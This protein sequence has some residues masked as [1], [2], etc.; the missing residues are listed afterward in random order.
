MSEIVQGARHGR[1]S[2]PQ[3]LLSFAF[4][5]YWC[6]TL[7]LMS[8]LVIFFRTR[9]FVSWFCCSKLQFVRIRGH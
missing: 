6:P 5:L 8:Y 4:L 9:Q 7:V 2:N 3:Y 1:R